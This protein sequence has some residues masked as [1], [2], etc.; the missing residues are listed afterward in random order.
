MGIEQ[1]VLEFQYKKKEHLGDFSDYQLRL[2][3]IVHI[4]KRTC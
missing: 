4:F 1:L 3:R 2:L